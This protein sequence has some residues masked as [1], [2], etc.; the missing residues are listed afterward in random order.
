MVLYLLTFV[1][2]ALV[3]IFYGIPVDAAL[4]ESTSATANVGLSA[5]VL[6]VG[7]PLP[8]KLVYVL[9]MWVG[10]LE[11]MAAFVLIGWLVAL[12]RGRV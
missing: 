1:A 10:R 7:N 4:F 3:G 9:Q 11:F 12:V 6:D 2:G 5:G 8:L